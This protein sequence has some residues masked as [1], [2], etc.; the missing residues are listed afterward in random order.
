MVRALFTKVLRRTQS[1]LQ[2]GFPASMSPRSPT[3][4]NRLSG[5]RRHAV[6]L[7]RGVYRGNRPKGSEGPGTS[8]AL[9][10]QKRTERYGRTF[11]GEKGD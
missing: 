7:V 4:S 5:T 2:R 10:L 8:R 1:V 6:H 9:M 11:R 3:A